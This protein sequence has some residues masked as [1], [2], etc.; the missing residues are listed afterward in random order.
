MINKCYRST[1][2]L[3]AISMTKDL[4][5][6]VVLGLVFSYFPPA[7]ADVD[8]DILRGVENKL[9]VQIKQ[10][11]KKNTGHDFL[12]WTKIANEIDNTI[13]MKCS[14]LKFP[15]NCKKLRDMFIEKS[16]KAFEA[17]SAG[18]VSHRSNGVNK[19]NSNKK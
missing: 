1:L 15:E 10:D 2:A 4:T 9:E 7:W 13:K 17:S 8:A 6:F 5:L 16:K 12:S 3:W 18:E 19:K 11:K 14:T